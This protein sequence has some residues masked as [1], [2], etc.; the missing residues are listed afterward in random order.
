MS[1]GARSVVGMEALRTR[2][3]D[4]IE[5]VRSLVGELAAPGAL[6]ASSDADL[7]ED[8]RWV[9]ELGRF[10]DTARILMAGEVA[11][12]CGAVAGPTTLADR[13]GCA[14]PTELLERVARVSPATA[15]LR[16]KLGARTRP[17]LTLT[18]QPVPAEFDAVR[19]GLTTGRLGVDAA[20]VI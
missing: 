7:L 16:L 6:P 2:F 9:E 3:P 12:R 13:A 4:T 15:R 14:T 5:Q 19:W 18:G 11:A 8:A 17:G 20:L 1:V 10:A